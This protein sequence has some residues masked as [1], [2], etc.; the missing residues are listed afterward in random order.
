[1]YNLLKASSNLRVRISAVVLIFLLIFPILFFTTGGYRGGMPCFFIL[2]VV[3]TVIL[4]ESIWRV[5]FTLLE[6][7]LYLFCFLM[8]HNC[9]GTVLYTP[10]D[11]EKAVMVGCLVSALVLAVVIYYYFKAYH[12]RQKEL[13]TTNGMKTEFLQDIRHEIRNPLHV[14]SLGVDYLHECAE[15]CNEEAEQTLKAIQSEAIRLGRMIDGMVEMAT[16]NESPASRMRVDFAQILSKCAEASR[17]HLEENRNILRIDI[18]P[19]LPHVFAEAEQL[20]RVVINLLS[21]AINCTQNGVISLE[22][23]TDEGYVIVSVKDTGEGI[24]PALL[25]R[26]FE[27]G[28]SGKGG[29]GYGLS[30]C[31][32]IVEAHG[33]TIEIESEE[34]AGTCI[35]FTIPAYGGQREVMEHE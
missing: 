26:V 18:T 15:S 23:K 30:I 4:L 27:R 21:N 25:P 22:A 7:T 24:S 9:P 16:M 3:L 1:M 28:V 5:V 2:A 17:F 33:G 19:G 20:A 10:Y 8:A 34:N 6:V 13:E 31:Q 35:T 11:T 29:K 14:I 32:T 12:K